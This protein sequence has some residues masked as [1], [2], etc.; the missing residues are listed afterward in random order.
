MDG[1]AVAG[2]PRQ[3]GSAFSTWPGR[4]RRAGLGGSGPL[5]RFADPRL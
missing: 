3:W 1:A 4:A 5:G 2:D